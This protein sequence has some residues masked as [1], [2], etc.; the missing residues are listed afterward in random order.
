MHCQRAGIGVSLGIDVIVKIITRQPTIEHLNTADLD[1]AI[2]AFG[3]KTGSFCIENN[4]A[5]G[6]VVRGGA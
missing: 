5:H 6:V 4:L 3:I 1:D 2:A